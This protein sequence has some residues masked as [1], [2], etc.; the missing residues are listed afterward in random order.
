MV[1]FTRL[2]VALSGRMP[3]LGGAAEGRQLWRVVDQEGPKA[4]RV[5]GDDP[6]RRPALPCPN[7]AEQREVA[8]GLTVWVGKLGQQGRC[9]VKA[10]FLLS[11]TL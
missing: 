1:C 11:T 8:I 4:A 9:S 2:T 5:R 3:R 10:T 7:P 6:Y